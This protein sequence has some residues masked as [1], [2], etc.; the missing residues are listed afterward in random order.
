MPP[1]P[2]GS[3]PGII[4][5]HFKLAGDFDIQVGYQIREFPKPKQEW[6]NLEVFVSGADGAA[7]VIRTNH[8]TLG[9][10]YALWHE[11]ADTGSVNGHWDNVATADRQGTLRLRR[12]GATLEFL[13]APEDSKDFQRVG[14]LDFGFAPIDT[15]S[16]RIVRTEMQDPTDVAFDRVLITADQVYSTTRPDGKF[17]AEQYLILAR[18]QWS[19]RNWDEALTLA[20]PSLALNADQTEPHLVAVRSLIPLIVRDYPAAPD[21]LKGLT[22]VPRSG[23]IVCSAQPDNTTFALY[24]VVFPGP[25]L[26]AV[27]PLPHLGLQ[28]ADRN[29]LH[30][31][32]RQ[33]WTVDLRAKKLTPA[34]P[35]PWTSRFDANLSAIPYNEQK[36]LWYLSHSANHGFV[37]RHNDNQ[38]NKPVTLSVTLSP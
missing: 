21:D 27:L 5:G 18:E 1:G 31:A 19:A 3:S 32:G 30:F 23:R 22:L 10:G 16:V 28:V 4:Q 35:V 13:A 12:T 33:W 7:A 34:G 2:A 25:R 29:R 37:A 17:R 15:V 6:Q 36:L 11:P 8:A 26:E 9:E 14:R 38:T 24:R 20:Q